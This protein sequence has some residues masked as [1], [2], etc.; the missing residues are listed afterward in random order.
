[1]VP[2]QIATYSYPDKT[3]KTPYEINAGILPPN[4]VHT[5][6]L[7]VKGIDAFKVYSKDTATIK[8]DKGDRIVFYDLAGI[9]KTPSEPLAVIKATSTEAELTVDI[10]KATPHQAS[11]GTS[12]RRIY[13]QLETSPAV[14]A[15]RV[16]LNA[17]LHAR[18]NT[19][20][21]VA[22]V[23]IFQPE[24]RRMLVRLGHTPPHTPR[25]TPAAVV[26]VVCGDDLN[27][28]EAVIGRGVDQFGNAKD[29]PAPWKVGYHTNFSAFPKPE[30]ADGWYLIGRNL[31]DPTPLFYTLA[32]YNEQR[33][34]LRLY[35]YNLAMPVNVS[36][37]TVEASLVRFGEQPFDGKPSAVLQQLKGAIF[38]LHPNP[39]KWSS[40][41]IPLVQWI[42]GSWACVQMPMLYPMAENVPV[43][44]AQAAAHPKDHYR[45]LYEE[46]LQKGLRGVQLSLLVQTYDYGKLDATL[47]GKAIGEAIQKMGEGGGPSALD[48][49]KDLGKAGGDIISGGKKIYDGIK[50]YRDDQ[51]KAKADEGVMKSLGSLL[52]MGSSIFSGGVG[53]GGA[54]FQFAN[55]LTSLFG[56]GAGTQPLQLAIELDLRGVI[57]G[58]LKIEHTFGTSCR[59]YLPGRFPIDEAYQ[60]GL[61]AE[62]PAVL[63]AVAPRYDRTMGLFGYR[64]N[65]GTL[66]LR[67]VRWDYFALW[68]RAMF[69][70]PSVAKPQRSW[71][72]SAAPVSSAQKYG[73]RSLDRLLP[74]V[75]NPYAEIKPM[76]PTVVGHEFHEDDLAKKYPYDFADASWWKH[77]RWQ[78]NIAWPANVAAAPGDTS[79]PHNVPMLHTHSATQ[80]YIK[81]FFDSKVILPA[82]I[83]EHHVEM[84]KGFLMQV[85]PREEYVPST[86]RTFKDITTA[87]VHLAYVCTAEHEDAT[88]IP[89]AKKPDP[90]PFQDVLYHWDVC[91]FYYGRTRQRADGSVPRYRGIAR[92]SSPVTVDLTRFPAKPAS[93]GAVPQVMHYD[94]ESRLLAR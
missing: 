5:W 75:Y 70:F 71:M 8:L 21:A 72:S 3:V 27:Y 48:V 25:P 59:F 30:P 51:K 53:I 82:G 23:V 42:R 86:Y 93:Y 39:H 49:L 26:A 16:V 66:K 57:K 52:S 68:K 11:D 88:D 92:L 91:Y 74:L 50:K 31:T 20:A 54:A 84:P 94:V 55:T 65:P 24:L 58:S 67:M 29:I 40:V 77:N 69:I 36:G 13:L 1:M 6:I 32:Y 44:P 81:A 46:P 9:K 83:H 47:E 4:F 14:T 38:P 37:A 78:F 35:L 85:P 73:A 41:R 61:L 87:Q 60:L 64:Y 15:R 56:G 63:A 45:S 62:N 79:F 12:R 19:G 76:V 33:G 89:D 17:H 22:L 18:P 90:S 10:S 28:T 34:I 43:D 7:D 2:L 80:I